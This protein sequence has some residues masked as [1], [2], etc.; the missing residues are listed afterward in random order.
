[1]NKLLLVGTVA[2]VTVFSMPNL[3]APIG[4]GPAPPFR[5]M[6]D[7]SKNTDPEQRQSIEEQGQNWDATHPINDPELR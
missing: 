3:A 4:R 5:D 1:M 6:Q 7:V 2:L